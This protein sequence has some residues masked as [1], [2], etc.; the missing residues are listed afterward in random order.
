[1]KTEEY[2]RVS[3]EFG[4]VY[5]ENSTILI[6]GSFPSVKSREAAFY[7]Q[8]PQNRFWKVLEALWEDPAGR[9]VEERKAFLLRHGIALWDVIESCEIIGSSDSAIRNVVPTKLR[10]VLQNAPIGRIYGNGN[11]AYQL[12]QKYHEAQ[13]GIP[14]TRLPSTS[15]ANAAWSL[16]RLIGAWSIIR[17]R[18]PQL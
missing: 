9:T 5:D 8:H 6:L 13:T 17:E 12:Y 18:G 16:E 10:K 14:M 15:P 1:M 7:Y 2:R 4:P 11:K 3:H